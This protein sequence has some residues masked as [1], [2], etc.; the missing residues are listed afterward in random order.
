MIVRSSSRL[1]PTQVRCA[2]G[3]IEVSWAIRSVIAT[4]RSRVE[5]P[6]PYVTDTNVGFSASSSRSA[7]QSW[8]SPSRS[9]GG[10]NS[11]ENERSPAEMSSR[12]VRAPPGMREGSPRAMRPG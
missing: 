9:F 5:P 10:K 2:S 12:T 1:W 8:R 6:A 7:F 11:K 3:V 4:V